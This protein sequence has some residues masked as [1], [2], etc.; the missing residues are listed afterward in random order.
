M[1]MQTRPS[2]QVITNVHAECQ[3]PG[4]AKRCKTLHYQL[5]LSSGSR[6]KLVLAIV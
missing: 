4:E 5:F 3:V 6:A 1:L 2:R